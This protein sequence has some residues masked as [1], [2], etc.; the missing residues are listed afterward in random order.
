MEQRE[1]PPPKKAKRDSVR[2]STMYFIWVVEER[3]EGMR[4]KAVFEEIMAKDPP[5]LMTDTNIYI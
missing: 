4:E 5:Y 1:D 3:I 2:S